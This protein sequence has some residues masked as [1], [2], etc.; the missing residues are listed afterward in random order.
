LF[1]SQPNIKNHDAALAQARALALALRAQYGDISALELARIHQIA[2]SFENW[3]VAAGRVVYLAECTR[4]PPR[5]R[6]NAAAL[7]A[8]SEPTAHEREQ[9]CE[10]IIAHELGHLLLPRPSVW[11]STAATEAAAHGFAQAWTGLAFH[12]ADYERNWRK[13]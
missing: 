8:F 9:L 11:A 13:A 10:V 12:P 3:E 6:V 7:A 2:V 1:N 5:I 4:Q